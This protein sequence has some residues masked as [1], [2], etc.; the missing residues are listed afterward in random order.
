MIA[1]IQGEKGIEQ[2]AIGDLVLS[3]DI[4]TGEIKYEVVE[5]VHSKQTEEFIEIEFEIEGIIK[6]VQCT[7]EHK[8]MTARG[9]VRAED[10]LENDGIYGI[11]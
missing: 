9:E 10:L 2:I 8:I 6:K 11:I 5:A 3:K 7:P 4:Q 1:T